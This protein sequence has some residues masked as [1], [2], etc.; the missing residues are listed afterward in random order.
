MGPGPRRRCIAVLLFWLAAPGHAAPQLDAREAAR[1]DREGKCAEAEPYYQQALRADS[2]SPAL[3][4]NAGNHY[5]LCGQPEK[6]R[7]QFERLLKSNP[8]HQNANLQLARIAAAERQGDQALAHLAR[9]KDSSL[10][11]LLIRAEALHWKGDAAAALRLLEG[12]EK[13]AGADPEFLAGLG[14]VYARTGHH[15]RAEAA[16]HALAVQRPGDFAVLVSLGRAA[17]RA[18]HFDRARESLEAALR[19]RPEHP[20]A[21]LEL[22]LVHASLDDYNRAVYLLARARQEAP[23]RGDILIAL[24]RA[25]ED[26]GYYGDSALAYDEYV[27]LNPQDEAARRDRARVL[28]YTGTRLD[29]GLREMRAY[30]AKRPGDP[31]GHYNLAQFSWR[32]KPEKSLEQLATAVR[33][34]PNFAPAH[35]SRAWLL[36]RLGRSAEALPHLEAALKVVPDD[37]RALDQLGLVYL[38]L[39]RPQDAEP[40]LRR[41]VSLA[42]GDPQALLHLGRAL[43]SLGRDDEAQGYLE[44]YQRLRPRQSR[45]PRKEPGMIELATLPEDARR[46]R[47]IERFRSM[48]RSR[49]DDPLL[50]AHLAGLLLAD[51]A[52]EDALSEYRRLLALNADG[53][54]W[55]QAGRALLQARQYEI[56]GEFL[57]RAVAGRPG[58]RV[59]LAIALLHTRGPAAALE[60]LER[61]PREERTGNFL[62]TKARLL[63][64]AGDRED[65]QKL[66]A[67]GMAGT[68]PGPQVVQQAAALLARYGRLDDAAN[69]LLRA[70]TAAPDENEIRLAHAVVLGLLGRDAEAEKLLN[71]IVARWPEWDRAYL[72]HALFL[73][74]AGRKTQAAQRARIAAALNPQDPAARCALARLSGAR[75]T[76]AWCD[77]MASLRDLLVAECAGR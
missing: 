57:E 58:A 37:V 4:N 30:V 19:I 14:A 32:E 29:E 8:D 49:P 65:A 62:L 76:D 26:A 16:L 17:A 5:L 25:A 64:A 27:R 47:E 61:T 56:A 60:A 28:G 46:A 66:L 13:Q 53:A 36:H 33:L 63:D 50:Q 44:K 22:G 38:S 23:G 7:A 59:D 12:I 67:E 41:A 70:T 21:L 55:A 3:L 42:P 34:D 73:E 6:A 24:A 48:S 51:G 71:E 39:D 2:P 35:V 43:V 9:L 54:V 72:A 1:L 40:V 75:P 52:V 18:R 68:A 31:L 10:T 45:N 11:V 69:L 15:G 77:C 20:D 74:Q